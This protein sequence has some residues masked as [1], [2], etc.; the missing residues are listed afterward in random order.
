[1]DFCLSGLPGQMPQVGIGQVH[2]VGMRQARQDAP[3][4]IAV[5]APVT[6]TTSRA[7]AMWMSG[8]QT[9][10]IGSTAAVSSISALGLANVMDHLVGRAA[11]KG[12]G[13]A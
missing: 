10:L 6:R 12:G 7:S 1:M 4:Q 9:C 3:R 8:H 13:K 5:T 2:D 11:K